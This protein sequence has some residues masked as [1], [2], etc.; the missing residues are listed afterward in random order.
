[1]KASVL[2]VGSPGSDQLLLGADL[3]P[4]LKSALLCLR[5]WAYPVL[6]VDMPDGAFNKTL[7]FLEALSAISPSSRV[8]LLTHAAATTEMLDIFSTS[9]IFNFAKSWED[10]QLQ[11]YILTAVESHR[12]HEQNEY[13][14]KALS[15]QNTTLLKLTSDLEARINRRA[16]GLDEKRAELNEVTHQIAAV[17]QA[18]IAVFR[19]ESIPELERRIS[20]TL[21]PAFQIAWTRIRYNSQTDINLK[22]QMT[23]SSSYQSDLIRGD[24]CVGQVTFGKTNGSFTRDEKRLLD[25]VVQSLNLILRR[26]ERWLELER[27][28]IGW[29][30]TFDAI[31]EPLSVI[32]EDHTLIRVNKEFARAANISSENAV[33]RKCYEVLF[34]K[35]SICSG[36]FLGQPFRLQLSKTRSG[37]ESVF[38]VSSQPAGSAQQTAGADSK[39]K[40][41][42]HLYRDISASLRAERLLVD[43]AKLAELGTISSSIAHELNNPLAGMLSYLQL[44]KMDLTKALQASTQAAAAGDTQQTVQE[45]EN[46]INEMED[47][48]RRCSAIVNSLLIYVR[49]SSDEPHETCSLVEAVLQAFQI[50]SLQTRAVGI[51]IGFEPTEAQKSLL[52]VGHLNLIAQIFCL[53]LQQTNSALQKRRFQAVKNDIHSSVMLSSNK[54]WLTIEITDTGDYIS[55]SNRALEDEIASDERDPGALVRQLVQ[56]LDGTVEFFAETPVG[57][58]VKIVLKNATDLAAALALDLDTHPGISGPG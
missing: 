14:V 35:E 7:A 23:D 6:V 41:Y 48:V 3:E 37:T 31:F 56:E 34:D 40:I 9:Q 5:T 39:G 20:E 28:R 55:N 16:T 46:D 52:T 10:P 21:G 13:L 17:H 58:R 2:L 44:I 30:S 27:A 4:D 1:M 11:D 24:M 36:C 49:K 19:A 15:D 45:L 54:D 18:L 12:D 26:L 8:I 33:G 22:F 51:R 57:R 50:V 47:S 53:V 43:S 25:Q 42:L 32:D 29:E 38:E